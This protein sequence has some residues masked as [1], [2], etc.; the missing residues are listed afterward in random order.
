MIAAPFSAIM[1]VDALMLVE[2]AAA[3]FATSTAGAGRARAPTARRRR[4]PS[5]G[6]PSLKCRWLEGGWNPPPGAVRGG[7]RRAVL[8]PLNHQYGRGEP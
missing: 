2:A 6:S 3:I 1:I 5:R 4:P 7:L 8:R